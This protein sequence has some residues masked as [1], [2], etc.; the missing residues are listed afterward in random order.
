MNKLIINFIILCVSL[1]CTFAYSDEIEKLVILGAG[2]AGLTSSLFT[3]Q[4]HLNPLVIEGNQYDG[5]ITAI[6][7]IENYPGIP[8]GISGRELAER[9]RGQAEKLGARFYPSRAVIVDLLQYPFHILLE[10]GQGIYC[11]SLIIATGASPR[12]LGLEAEAALIGHGVSPSATLDAE[13]FVDKEVIVVGGGDSAMDQALLLTNYASRVTIIHKDDKLSGTPYLQE[14]VQK[15][16]KIECKFNS[17]IADI[18]GANEGHVTGVNL[19]NLKTQEETP[20]SCEGVFVCIGRK[21]NT[22]LFLGQLEMTEKGYIVTKPDSNST[23][24][25]GVFAAGD[26]TYMSGRRVIAAV[27]SGSMSAA[28]VVKFFKEKAK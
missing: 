16:S 7:R 21:P 24:I 23:S 14:R 9:I 4:A 5:Q 3:A 20:L 15:N 19:K 18:H 6:Y 12:W 11:E 10:D 13:K 17:E 22:D 27:G 1:N 2:P 8:E 28:D 26:I 25:K